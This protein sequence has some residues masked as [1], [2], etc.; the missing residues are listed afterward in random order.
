[1]NTRIMKK[2]I[3]VSFAMLTLF[4]SCNDDYSDKFDIPEFQNVKNDTITLSDDD[5]KKI[6]TLSANKELAQSM[7][8]EGKSYVKV[9]EALEN[10]K[11]FADREHANLFLPAFINN[12]Y[13]FLDSFSKV[14]V[15]YKEYADLPAYLTALNSAADYQLTEADYRTVWA[16]QG[17]VSFLSPSTLNQIPELLKAAKKDAKK[18]DVVMVKYAYSDTEPSFGGEGGQ[19]DPA[20][21]YTNIADILTMDGHYIAKGEVIA[22]YAK[23]FLLKDETASIL[24]Y[25]NGV[26]NY[27]VGDVVEVE[28]DVEPYNNLRQFGKGAT[29]TFAER[30]AEFKYPA[31]QAMTGA[32]MEA[33][34]KKAAI[35]Y[36]SLTGT[37]AMSGKFYNVNM[38]GTNLQASISNPFVS[39]AALDG[40]EITI[41][42]Y[43]FA[44]NSSRVDVMATAVYEKGAKNDLTPVGQV[45]LSADGVFKVQG[46]VVAKNKFGFMLND[47]TGTIYVN[48]TTD[49]EI[50]ALVSVDGATDSKYGKQFGNEC[51]ITAVDATAKYTYPTPRKLDAA[52]MDAYIQNPF[53]G[54]VSYEGEL[55][56]DGKYYN[57][58][59]KGASVALGSLDHPIA[60]T[61]KREVDGKQVLVTS[62][63]YKAASDKFVKTILTSIEEVVEQP[64]ARS[65]A[66]R[67]LI[68]PTAHA[69]YQFDGTDWYAYQ[70]PEE[71]GL[72]VVQPADYDKMGFTSIKNPDEVLPVYLQLALPYAKAN[73]VV[74]VGYINN[75]KKVAAS[76]CTFDGTT[77]TLT[78]KA[79]DAV[80]SFQKKNG[81]WEE[82][83]IYFEASFINGND[84]DFTP[85]DI[86]TDP[87]LSS[88]WKLE[89]KYGW[90]ASGFKKPTNY[91]TDSY[92]V[93]PEI[94]L[95][96]AD[97]PNVSFDCAIN[98][99]NGKDANAV[100]SVEVSTDYVDEA[101]TAT[102]KALKV[103]G[104]PEGSSWDFFPVGPVDL[105]AY[106][107][108]KIRLAF[109]YRSYGADYEDEKVKNLG[110]T[111][112]IKN[113]VVGE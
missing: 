44:Y 42:G 27:N 91:T 72:K 51:T 64:A 95:T 35:Q 48:K 22:T 99:L 30:K 109:R 85:N 110:P 104:W 53:V 88:V 100:I 9:L 81:K 71:I 29:V 36:V 90:K 3:L 52:G 12:K 62:Y 87:E 83:R 34:T 46:S 57:V 58:I 15:H 40:K 32:E 93:S 26:P 13:P 63:A 105:S 94:D 50:G 1:M 113:L 37:L 11:Y 54:Y 21:T 78:T 31:P 7:D 69:L 98:F 56:I 5:Y 6:A 61:I 89:N 39:Y 111:I 107:G 75:D 82:V 18:D 106:N 66:T 76:E 79:S 2:S 77:W 14:L 108:Q 92:L 41:E 20:P 8:P 24:V 49:N 65:L 112:E 33:W 38:E 68:R 23:G 59:V 25:L 84:G 17:I 70:T 97:F 74:V 67:A 101:E 80:M 47:G 45:L 43:L 103:E 19:V 28:G 4:A 73:D 10:N 55:K 86:V 102:W 60:E 16:D 96:K